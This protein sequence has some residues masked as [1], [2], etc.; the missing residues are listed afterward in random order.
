[1]LGA[2]EAAPRFWAVVQTSDP[3]GA[4]QVVLLGLSQAGTSA[5]EFKAVQTTM[6]AAYTAAKADW[7]E[8][9][10]AYEADQANRSKPFRKTT[11]EPAKP[12]VKM[13]GSALKDKAAAEDLLTKAQLAALAKSDPGAARRAQVITERL[14]QNFTL[15]IQ[16]PASWIIETREQQGA[17]WACMAGYLSHVVDTPNDV[18]GA[19]VW[20]FKYGSLRQ[21]FTDAQSAKVICWNTWYGLAEA[22][23]AKYKPTPGEAT[24]VNAK[25][26]STMI[27]YWA[28][29]KKFMMMAKEFEDVDCVLQ[30]EPDE[31]GHL[32]LSCDFDGDKPGVVL[33]GNSGMPELKGL[34]DTV[35]GWARGFRVLRDLYAPHVILAANPSAWDRNGTMTGEKW[36]AYFNALEVN[37]A[38]GWDLFI[39]QLHDWDHGQDK[40]G[41]NAKYPPYKEA[42]IVTYHGS[43]DNWC[44]WIKPIHQATGMW[45]VAWQLPQGNSTYATCDGS[46]GHGMDGVAELLLDN[47][48]ANQVAQRMVAAGCAMWIFSPG[49]SGSTLADEQ[50]DGITNP[51]PHAG[52]KGLKSLFADDDGGYLRLKGGEY[53]LNPV[54]IQAKPAGRKKKS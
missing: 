52:S 31:W 42:D 34:P 6:T 10:K 32:L 33:V 51:T 23:P 41:A 48:P 7:D 30:I 2:E 39:T 18:E 13:V 9:R 37:G 11:P 38:N 47:H 27:A 49:G 19:D 20:F 14:L 35:K 53:F 44:A 50:K 29:T 22:P 15:G 36:G 43:V 26:Q 16:A 17:R 8:L 28:M 3:A 54:P 21:K 45:G 40:N 4:Q 25:V 24:P 1:M 12:L 46:E 5:P